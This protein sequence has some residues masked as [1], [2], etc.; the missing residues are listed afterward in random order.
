MN[1]SFCEFIVKEFEKKD[2]VWYLYSTLFALCFSI[3]RRD[4]LRVQR[5]KGYSV[6]KATSKLKLKSSVNGE[7]FFPIPPM[8]Q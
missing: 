7:G 1:S 5:F 3:P 4:E 6:A 8:K 2:W